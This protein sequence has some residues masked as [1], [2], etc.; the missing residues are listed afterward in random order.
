MRQK[1]LVTQ[2]ALALA[3][4]YGTQAHAQTAADARED[5]TPASVTPAGTA[6]LA[7]DAPVATVL[8]TGFRSSLQKALNLKQQAIGVRDSIVAEDIGKFPEANIAESLQRVPGVILVRDESSGEGQRIS[9]RGLLTAYSVT[10]L[11]GAP[12]NATSTSGIGGAAR[13]FNYNVFASEL[14]GRVDFYKTPLAELTEGGLGG[15]V[16]L[17]SPRPFDNPKGA[18][19]Y[20]ATASYNTTSKKIDP[21]GFALMSKTWGQWGLL[22]GGSHSGGTNN[23]SGFEAGGGYNSSALGSQTPVRGNFALALDYNDPRANLSGY[24]REQVDAWTLTAGGWPNAARKTSAARAVRK[25]LIVFSRG[26]FGRECVEVVHVRGHGAQHRG[27]LLGCQV[28]LRFGQHLEA[29]HELAHGG[30]TQQRWIEMGV[31]L[32]AVSV[33]TPVIRSIRGAMPAHRVRE[34]GLE[35]V[36]VAR[37]QALEGERQVG[38]L[39]IGQVVEAAHREAR[40]QQGLERPRSPVGHDGQPVFGGDHDPLLGLGFALDHV[41]QER[42]AMLGPVGALLPVFARQQVGQEACRPYLP[43]RV[44]IGAPH[45]RALVLEDL[46]PAVALAQLGRLRAPGID[47]FAQRRQR[48]LGQ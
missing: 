28:T 40:Q 27:C 36:V 26:G 10:T 22:V 21:M 43:V 32:P 18:V 11:N 6:A 25:S 35:Q 48:E 14:F 31:Q 45:R 38:A 7:A 13:G 3:T 37:G 4:A 17:Q 16:D 47:H 42:A 1:M 39:G 44:G 34:R 9:I 30:R 19:R 8:V 33:V 5:A 46:D 41:E 15:V 20:G 2:L 24:T 12:V 29:D 23:R